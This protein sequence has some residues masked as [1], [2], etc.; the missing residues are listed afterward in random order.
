MA[1]WTQKSNPVHVFHI[2]KTLYADKY[3]VDREKDGRITPDDAFLIR[4]YV[5][6]RKASRHLSISRV[7]KIIFT[8]LRWRAYTPPFRD[9]IPMHIYSA[10]DAIN[11]A[12]D[13]QGEPLYAKNTIADTIII[14]KPFYFWMVEEGH[15]KIPLAKIK[16]IQR[17]PQQ[18][19]TKTAEDLLTPHEIEQLVRACTWTRDRA[20]IYTLYEGGFRIGELAALTWGD[21]KF[22]EKGIIVTVKAQKTEKPRYLRLVMAREHLARWKA[23][24]PGDPDTNALVFITKG[25]KPI[26]YNSIVIQIQR[27]AIRAGIKKRITPHLFRHSRITDLVRQGVPES[28]IKQMMWNNLATDMLKAYAHLTGMDIDTAILE[29]NDIKVRSIGAQPILKP[30]QCS[31]CYAIGSPTSKFCSECGNPLTEEAALEYGEV[32][33]KLDHVLPTL[34]ADQLQAIAEVVAL[35]L[36]K[37]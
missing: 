20:L 28:V 9:H 27:L 35:K 6:E 8:L 29:V 19:V 11:T 10:I 37:E 24:Y 36:K 18:L 32:I 16:A 22:D 21:I 31:R 2:N 7:N 26:A 30:R 25:K 3:L 13:E 34:N 4:S 12:T 23:D 5:A 14:V 17:P 33:H 1:D 15:S